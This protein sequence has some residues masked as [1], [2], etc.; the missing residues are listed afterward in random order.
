MFALK[1]PGIERSKSDSG[2]GTGD[3]LTGPDVEG[4]Q[5]VAV[6]S[7][8]SGVVTNLL[9]QSERPV[10]AG[11]QLVEVGDIQGLE[12]QIDSLWAQLTASLRR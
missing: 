7:P 11:A 5:V 9:Q 8:V 3:S 10:A 2:G 6:T 1:S 12:A 4:R